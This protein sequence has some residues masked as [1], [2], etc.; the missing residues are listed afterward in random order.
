M[1]CFGVLRCV[2]LYIRANGEFMF[3]ARFRH[4]RRTSRADYEEDVLSV[5]DV[6]VQ[7]SRQLIGCVSAHTRTHIHALQVTQWGAQQR[8][9]PLC[10]REHEI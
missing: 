2:A 4:S 3:L 6:Q 9:Q 5:G 10:L 1:F 7:T 8:E